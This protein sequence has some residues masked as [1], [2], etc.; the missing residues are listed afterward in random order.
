MNMKL[1]FKIQSYRTNAVES[2][3]D[4]FAG[5]VKKSGGAYRID[6]GVRKNIAG[7]VDQDLAQLTRRE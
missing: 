7:S 2:V 5:Q 3:F 1:K 6:P 4:C